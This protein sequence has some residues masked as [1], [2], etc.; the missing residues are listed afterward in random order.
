MTPSRLNLRIPRWLAVLV[1]LAALLVLA[2]CGSS[3]KATPTPAPAANLAAPFVI[4]ADTVQGTANLPK[5]QQ[6]TQTCVEENRFP[7]NAEVVFRAKV[8]D[9]VTGKSLDASGLKSVELELPNGNNMAMKFGQHPSSNPTDSFWS[10]SWTI[11]KDY[12]TGS[13]AWK[14]VATGNDG[15]TYT[16]SPFNVAPSQMTITDQV[17]PTAGS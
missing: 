16:Y 12:P 1:P 6:A 11:P 9:A 8:I 4:Q 3:S 13:V 10:V 2:G 7:R 15:K 5:D 14:I 17:L